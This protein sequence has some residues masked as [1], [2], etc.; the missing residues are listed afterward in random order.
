MGG[1][2]FYRCYTDSQ[3]YKMQLDV[4][5]AHDKIDFKKLKNIF[6][7]FQSLQYSSKDICPWYLMHGQAL[8]TVTH[9]LFQKAM[10]R[11]THMKDIYWETSLHNHTRRE[12]RKQRGKWLCQSSPRWRP[13][14][15]NGLVSTQF[16][17]FQQREIQLLSIFNG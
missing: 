12:P 15:A 11:P 13:R 6:S 2:H 14:R 16:K 4:I 9:W 5:F 8:G 17:D 3:E 10:F 1:S 7:A